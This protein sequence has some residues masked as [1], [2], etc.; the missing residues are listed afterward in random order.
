[1]E[2]CLP[3]MGGQ[4]ALLCEMLL[5]GRVEVVLAEEIGGGLETWWRRL[6][7]EEGWEAG[8]CWVCE[9]LRR[10]AQT[11]IAFADVKSD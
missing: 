8:E 2:M 1:M 4:L 11:A 6:R 10:F 3:C 9:A 5:V 7:C